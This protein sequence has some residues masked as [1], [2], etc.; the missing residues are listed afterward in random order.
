MAISPFTS[1]KIQ[2]TYQQKGDVEKERLQSGSIKEVN[3]T[4]VARVPLAIYNIK[5]NREISFFCFDE[6]P[7]KAIVYAIE[8]GYKNA[9]C[10]LEENQIFLNSDARPFLFM[11]LDRK[12]QILRDIVNYKINLEISNDDEGNTR[13]HSLTIIEPTS[14]LFKKGLL[15]SVIAVFAF[16]FYLTRSKRAG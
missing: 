5:G 9:I 13:V 14:P 16:G 4:T 10:T 11:P 12:K 7:I 6:E 15:I 8:R 3:D 1:E 2:K